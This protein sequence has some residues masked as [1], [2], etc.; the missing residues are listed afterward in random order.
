MRFAVAT[1]RISGISRAC[2]H[3]LVRVAH[4]GILQASQRYVRASRIEYVGPPAL[5]ALPPHLRAAWLKIQAD[6]ESTYLQALDY[7]MQKGDA[8]YILP[9][10]CTTSLCITGNYQMWRDLLANRTDKAAQWEIRAVA[11]QI[12][13]ILAELAPGL[14][15]ED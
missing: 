15:W 11:L 9:H 5:G 12:R 1:F 3:Q 2:S 10:G 7:G 14:G 13:S 8:R 4:A 6:A